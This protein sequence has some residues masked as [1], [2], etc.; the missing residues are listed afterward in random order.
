MHIPH[1]ASLTL[2]IF[3]FVNAAQAATYYVSSAG[4][5]AADGSQAT[6]WQSIAKV[7]AATLNA[8]DQVLF[9]RGDTFRGTL[10]PPG[11]GA[12]GNPITFGAY[13]SGA[14]PVISGL[15]TIADASWTSVGNSLYEATVPNGGAT[16]NAVFVGGA[17]QKLARYPKASAANGGYLAFD[18]HSGQT[19]ITDADLAGVANVAGGEVVIR[20]V[21][22]LDYRTSITTHSG[23]TLT[24]PQFVQFATYPLVD[25]SGYFV[26][27]HPAL[28]TVDGEWYYR[29]GAKMVG[30]HAAKAPTGVDVSVVDRLVSMTSR[31]HL[32][33]QDLAFKGSNAEAI[34]GNSVTDIVIQQCDIDFAGTYAIYINTATDVKI[35]HNTIRDSLSDSVYVRTSMSNG[36]T[37]TDNLIQRS[38]LVI[39]MSQGSRTS[40]EA[41]NV[42]VASNAVIARNTII[43]TGFI[44][45]R[46]NG[47]DV[48]VENN[49]I[50]GF[51]S[52]LD[53]GG[54]IYTWNG[55][56]TTFTNR[57][58][59]NNVITR[60]IGAKE[61][62]ISA[63][64]QAN[65]IY[66][67]NNTNHVEVR[68]N[69]VYRMANK[70]FH[71]NSPQDIV[72]AQN[73]FFDNAVGWSMA[74]WP[75]DGSAGG[76]GGQDIVN[77]DIHDNIFVQPDRTQAAFNYGDRGVNFPAASTLEARLA[78]SGSSDGNYYYDPHPIP[79]S[80]FYRPDKAS[81]FVIPPDKS[82]E[83][84]QIFSTFE[85]TSKLLPAFPYYKI[86][87]LV[88]TNLYPEGS[89][90]SGIG[91][92]GGFPA[93]AYTLTADTTSK[94][95]GTGSL[96]IDLTAPANPKD[97]VLFYHSIGPVTQGKRYVLRFST[98]GTSDFGLLRASIRKSTNPYT[99]LTAQEYAAFGKQRV[100]HEFVLEPNST[101]PDGSWKIDIL[102]S[103]GTVYIDDV[104]I[105]EADVSDL[106]PR[107]PIR[108]EVNDTIA[109]KVVSLSKVYVDARD[110]PF[111][112][113]ITLQPYTSVVL[114]ES[115]V[116]C[117]PTM[118]SGG[119]GGSG[120]SSSG[121]TGSSS[122]SGSGSVS[123]SGSGGAGGNMGEGGAGGS[124]PGTPNGAEGCDCASTSRSSS[125]FGAVMALA[126]G[127]LSFG[128]R[129]GRRTALPCQRIS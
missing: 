66:L 86:N 11:S 80:T 106:D 28:A 61:G 2:S 31:N 70:G 83:Q 59:L 39:G 18:A 51:C 14:K 98:L 121:S 21:H 56:K 96:R 126:L 54:A 41:V 42:T 105:T 36:V 64:T 102:Q 75:D 27:N 23:N 22:W 32:V 73:T 57:R 37:V 25:G 127:V 77:I 120:S 94:L 103:S 58:V 111:C 8:G 44:P 38:G 3:F 24:F 88:G 123:S 104:Q 12:V 55:P 30:L 9:R 117:D 53:D 78:A 40:N 68:G 112:G 85:A 93:G 119:A 82:F 6:P 47:N 100:D 95:T 72:I 87:A 67:D 71:T 50:D 99:T 4:S 29:S 43:D 69:T 115:N 76:N 35:D 74:R 5:D 79:F 20:M 125:G 107:A 122:S 114:F 62:T 92:I 116:P 109:P 13:G 84:W 65:G 129:R 108:F 90:E 45:I 128:R 16:L 97:Y 1:V 91:T 33:F 118:G 101:E 34:Y 19:S 60:G 63:V 15:V 89:F 10:T 49:V 113:D 7:N 81:P 52:V 26:Q 17:L 110:N 46:F 48:T 124:T